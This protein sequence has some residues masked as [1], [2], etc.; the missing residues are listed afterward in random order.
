MTASKSPMLSPAVIEAAER[1]Q[2]LELSSEQRA[3]LVESV[4]EQMA[5]IEAVRQTPRPFDLQPALTFNPRLPGRSYPAQKNRLEL[6]AGDPGPLP[7]DDAS[8]AY[9]PVT[10]LAFWLRSG[11]L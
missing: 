3:L 5:A 11:V 1:L 6:A 7:A 2:G 8:I 10:S 9:A 4:P